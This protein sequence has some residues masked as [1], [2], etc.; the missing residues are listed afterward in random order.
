VPYRAAHVF[1]HTIWNFVHEYEWRPIRWSLSLVLRAWL[2]RASLV[3]MLYAIP[4]L[5][6]AIMAIAA[7][8]DPDGWILLRF[9]VAAMIAC[10]VIWWLFRQCDLRNRDIRTVIGNWRWGSGDP[11]TFPLDWIE[12]NGFT[13]RPLYGTTTFAEGAVNCIKIHNWWGAMFAARMCMLL[14][15]RRAGMELTE[16]ILIDPE[17]RDGIAAVRADPGR[18]DEL[19][20]PGRYEK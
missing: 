2:R 18:W 12:E 1:R 5:G 8:D 6:F 4:L 19:L 7:K 15:D 17:V 20:G 14:E 11:W 9:C 3:A 13:P 10:P 16:T